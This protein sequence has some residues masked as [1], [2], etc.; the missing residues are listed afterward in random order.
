VTVLIAH[1]GWSRSGT[2]SYCPPASG[3]GALA[4]HGHLEPCPHID[5][6]RR[7]LDGLNESHTGSNATAMASAADFSTVRSSRRGNELRLSR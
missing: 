3:N 7:P 5:G 1:S 6:G 2:S 4:R